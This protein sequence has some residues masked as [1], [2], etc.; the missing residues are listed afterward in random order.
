MPTSHEDP[1]IESNAPLPPVLPAVPVLPEPTIPQPPGG[2]PTV[3]EAP[4][5]PGLWDVRTLSLPPVD[6]AARRKREGW[7]ALVVFLV[8]GVVGAGVLYRV[9]AIQRALG[10][11]AADNRASTPDRVTHGGDGSVLPDTTFVR[12]SYRVAVYAD[13]SRKIGTEAGMP[14]EEDEWVTAE[15]DYVTPIASLTSESQGTLSALAPR[16]IIQTNEYTY[17]NGKLAGD[18]WIR[19]PHEPTLDPLTAL[20][21][22]PMYQ[23]VVTAEVRAAASNVSTT[24]E[25]VRGIPVTTYVFDTPWHTLA[26]F[27]DD[28]DVNTTTLPPELGDAHVTLSV[29]AD[30]L[31]RVSD[32]QFVEQAWVDAAATTT[33]M[34]WYVHIRIDI[35]ST[36]NEPSTVVPPA[37]FIE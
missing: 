23:D 1:P 11:A 28:G 33:D 25:V 3:V 27:A 37:S 2:S 5:R 10:T 9:Q 15:V 6:R 30:G 35:V 24:N 22:L 29:D 12:P 16:Q 18:P 34:S 20:D 13:T 17:V 36:S 4:P 7:R 19:A 32:Y 14:F 8:L 26:E 31:I 21:F